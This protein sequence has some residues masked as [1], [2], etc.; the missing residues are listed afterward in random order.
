MD[1]IEIQ[2]VERLGLRMNYIKIELRTDW[3]REWI[4]L[5]L[6]VLREWRQ[7]AN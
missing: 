4:L 6:N 7:R 1:L 2:C 3:D 5:R